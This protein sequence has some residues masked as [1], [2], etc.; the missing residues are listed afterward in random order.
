MFNVNVS[1]DDV[2]PH[3][4]SSTKVLE[5]C[6]ELIDEFEDIKFTLFV[7]VSYWRTIPPDKDRPDTRTESPLQI[8]LHP[9]FCEDLRALPEKNFEIAYHGYFHGIPG[10]SNNDEFKNMSYSEA[11]QRFKLI[12]ETVEKAGLKDKFKPIFRPPAWRMSAEAIKAA[13]DL[14]IQILALHPGAS[15]RKIYAGEEEEFGNV[16]YCTSNP[17]FDPLTLCSKAEIVYH[18]CEWDRNYLDKEKT[19]DL[20]KFFRSSYD[21]ID[22]CF[23]EDLN[24]DH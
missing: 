17:P 12:F 6:Y 16:V 11:I 13:K 3:T 2:S 20:I 24:G 7:P 22:F 8:N 5:R 21:K 19:Q 18:A 15:Y 1:V 9:E 23:M 4:L 14:D 10:E